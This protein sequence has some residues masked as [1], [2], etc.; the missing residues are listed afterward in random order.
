M[1]SPIYLHIHLSTSMNTYSTQSNQSNHISPRLIQDSLYEML[2]N[3]EQDQCH[4][5]HMTLTYKSYQDRVYRESDLNRFFIN[6]YLKTL[7]PDIFHTRTWTKTKK[8]NQP[9]VLAFIDEHE[10]KPVSIG[11]HGLNRDKIFTYPS[12]LHHHVIIA[13]KPYTTDFFSNQTGENTLLNYSSLFMTTDLR[14]C[15]ADRM[16]YA[17]KMLWKFPDYQS[18]GYQ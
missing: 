16:Y 4:L 12:R 8:M 11:R 1:V 7:L 2:T 13:S 3:L 18:F 6:Y 9:V 10:T 15:N 17:S 14:P 5:F